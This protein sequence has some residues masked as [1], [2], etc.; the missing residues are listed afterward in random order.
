MMQDHV[1]GAGSY[2]PMNGNH[3]SAVGALSMFQQHHKEVKNQK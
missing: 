3:A 1:E 2:T